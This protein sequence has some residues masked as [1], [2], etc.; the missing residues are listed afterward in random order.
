MVTTRRDTVSLGRR[1]IE[2][3]FKMAVAAAL[4]FTLGVCLCLRVGWDDSEETTGLTAGRR[5]RVTHKQKERDLVFFGRTSY[6]PYPQADRQTDNMSLLQRRNRRAPSD[7]DRDRLRGRK[8][9]WAVQWRCPPISSITASSYH[10]GRGSLPRSP[11]PF[12]RSFV[13]RRRSLSQTQL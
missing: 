10:S 7:R 8:R 12:A 9:A 13:Q 6:F 11:F 3:F 1:R 5:V 2:L 4:F